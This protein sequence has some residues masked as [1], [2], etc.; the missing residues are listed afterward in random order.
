METKLER[1]IRQASLVLAVA[2]LTT[3]VASRVLAAQNF[4]YTQTNLTSNLPNQAANQDTNL[5][6]AWGVAFLPSSL[7]PGGSP[8]WISDNSSGLST[9]YD[10]AGALVAPPVNIPSP[11]SMTGGTPTGLVSNLNLFTDPT[12][13]DF[14]SDVF[15]FDTEDGTIVGWQ[16][17]PMTFNTQAVVRVDNSHSGTV[18]KGLAIANDSNGDSHLYAANFNSGAVDVFDFDYLANTT[19]PGKFVDPKLP[20]AAALQSRLAASRKSTV[21]PAL[22]TA[23]YKYFHWLLTRTYVSFRRQPFPPG[24]LRC[25]NAVSSNGMYLSTHRCRLE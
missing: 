25:R 12:A 11:T 18:Y 5:Q 23:R 17:P 14:M 13:N 10:A 4:L 7:F 16:T 15:I 9:L 3:A 1:K 24:R 8:F 21:R 22:S 19:L 6:N 20:Q 2:F